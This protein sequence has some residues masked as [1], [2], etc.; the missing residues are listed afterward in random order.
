MWGSNHFDL[1]GGL[2]TVTALSPNPALP[3]KSRNL[4]EKILGLTCSSYK[5]S[6]VISLVLYLFVE[7]PD[8][9][10]FVERI[11]G[12]YV[13][14]DH[15]RVHY[16]EY[17]EMADR[18]LKATIRVAIKPHHRCIFTHDNDGCPSIEQRISAILRDHPDLQ[19]CHVAIVRQVIES[20]Y[21]AGLPDEDA[22]HLHVERLANTNDVNEEAYRHATERISRRSALELKVEIL[23]RYSIPQARERNH[24]FDQFFRR[25]C[26]S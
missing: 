13:T 2:R 8:D 12:A 21:L 22:K 7:G 3:R 26:M 24:S 19:P 1:F 14:R 25:Y 23:N 15:E 9:R 16:I 11:L 10:R 4:L 6:L 5:A 18:D 17:A 20:W